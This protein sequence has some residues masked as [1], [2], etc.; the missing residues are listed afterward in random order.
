MKYTWSRDTSVTKLSGP[1]RDGSNT[2]VFAP[3]TYEI[4]DGHMVLRDG[5]QLTELSACTREFLA[6]SRSK[7][8]STVS[9][10]WSELGAVEVVI[11][12]HLSGPPYA[13][14][15]PVYLQYCTRFFI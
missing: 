15:K 1:A 12:G 11:L 8:T 6:I 13:Y 2:S 7:E 4:D 9:R 3:L 10:R 14:D 5:K